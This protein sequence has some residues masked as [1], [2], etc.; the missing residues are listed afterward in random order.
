MLQ[1]IILG[2]VAI[3]ILAGSQNLIAQEEKVSPKQGQ[4]QKQVKKTPKKETSGQKAMQTVRCRQ[5]GTRQQPAIKKK[6][7]GQKAGKTVRLG[8]AGAGKQFAAKKRVPKQ[9]SGKKAPRKVAGTRRGQ[10]T[11][12]KFNRWVSAIKK[13]YRQ[14]NRKKMGRLLRR[15]DK[16]QQQLQPRRMVHGDGRIGMRERAYRARRSRH[17]TPR[18]RGRVTPALKNEEAKKIGWH[19]NRCQPFFFIDRKPTL[20]FASYIGCLPQKNPS[21]SYT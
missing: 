7:A 14:N 11:L 5:A 17:K 19:H 13:A 10:R 18:R 3:I 15:M 1:K 16:V 20:E 8:R 9:F 4:K 21:R 6:V 12:R 2:I